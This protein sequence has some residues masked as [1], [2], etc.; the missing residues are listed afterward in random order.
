MEEEIRNLLNCGYYDEYHDYIVELN[1]EKM[2]DF[3]HIFFKADKVIFANKDMEKL[4]KENQ[5]LQEQV[6]CM[7]C[8]HHHEEIQE[9]N[10][11]IEKLKYNADKIA[12]EIIEE[13]NKKYNELKENSKILI[14][15]FAE[16][17]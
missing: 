2:K 6:Q 9:L 10:E 15:A 14:K 16:I 8:G 4:K 13:Q 12:H 1:E 3:F 11:Q 5:N 17:L 7:K